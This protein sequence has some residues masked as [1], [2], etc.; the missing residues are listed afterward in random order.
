MDEYE[1]TQKIEKILTDNI[2]TVP[3]EGKE[4]NKENIIFELV[5][6]IKQLD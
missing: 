6:L 1:L 4:I 2:E 5:K 3:Y